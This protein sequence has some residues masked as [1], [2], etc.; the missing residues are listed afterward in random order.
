VL[1]VLLEHPFVDAAEVFERADPQLGR[2]IAAAVVLTPGVRADEAVA[3]DLLDAV[4]EVLGGLSRPRALA[5]V[6]RFGDELPAAARRRALALLTARAA[7]EPVHVTWD[8]V[9][10]ASA[11]AEP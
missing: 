4:R 5:F 9:L 8:Q 6:D 1:E 2:S 3:R 7:D 10:S 11:V